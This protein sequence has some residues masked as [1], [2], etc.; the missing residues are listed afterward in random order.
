MSPLLSRPIIHFG[1][2]KCLTVYFARGLARL[3]VLSSTPFFLTPNDR[4][5]ASDVPYILLSHDSEVPF[6][7]ASSVRASHVIRDPRDLVVS[8]YFY[9]LRTSEEWCAR[10]NPAH[11][12]LPCDVSYQDHLRSISKEAGLIYEMQH[13]S[14]RVT[15]KMAEW[16]YDRPN[17]L[18]LKFEQIVGNEQA[19]FAEVFDWY[20]VPER[21]K[22]KLLDFVSKN[23]RGRLRFWKSFGARRHIRKGSHVGQWKSHFTPSVKAAFKERYQLVLEHLG[24]EEDHKW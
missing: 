6:P 7:A 1:Y 15:E 3:G 2:H 9:H 19:T 21:L 4:P 24:Y 22:S 18:E 17:C 16:D 23:A 5:C 14:G 20:G 13:V 10:P 8:A 11:E 12:D